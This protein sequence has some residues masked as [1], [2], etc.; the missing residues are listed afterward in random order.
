MF[1]FSADPTFHKKRTAFQQKLVGALKPVI[2]TKAARTKAAEG[3][4]GGTTPEWWSAEDQTEA[5]KM[6]ASR[7]SGSV[8]WADD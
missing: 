4:F 6:T 5:S 7:Y 8:L 3:I 2:G 1:V